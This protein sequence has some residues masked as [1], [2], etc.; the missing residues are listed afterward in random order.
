VFIAATNEDPITTVTHSI[1]LIIAP[2]AFYEMA[3]EN[4]LSEIFLQT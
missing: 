3:G 1:D 4:R 2:S